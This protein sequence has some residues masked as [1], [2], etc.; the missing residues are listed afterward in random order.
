MFGWKKKKLKNEAEAQLKQEA[1]RLDHA[2]NFVRTNYAN[3]FLAAQKIAVIQGF[4]LDPLYRDFWAEL[5]DVGGRLEDCSVSYAALVGDEKMSEL[6]TELESKSGF[7]L[8]F[9]DQFQEAISQRDEV[10][11]KAALTRWVCRE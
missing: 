5:I 7:L 9:K 2:E 1:L 11:D 8:G 10:F 6:K 3:F 4:G